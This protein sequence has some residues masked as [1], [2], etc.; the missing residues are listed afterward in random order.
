M[1]IRK[2]VKENPRARENPRT[3]K[4]LIL[5]NYDSFTYNLYQYIGELKGNSVVFRNDELSLAEIQAMQPSHIVISPGPGRPERKKD[6]GVCLEVIRKFEGPILGVCLGHQGMI[7]AM[8][9]KII[10]APEIMHGKVSRVILKG[11][12]PLFRGLSREITVMRYH[13]LI[14]ERRSLPKTLKVIAET[15]IGVK[16]N[17][18]NG[19]KGRGKSTEKNIIMGVQ[20]VS[21]PLFGVQ[22]HPESVGTTVGKQILKNFLKMKF[23]ARKSTA[24]KTRSEK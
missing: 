20:H 3:R 1:K 9:G 18:S 10:Q 11:G 2:T 24:K 15:R 14:G 8:G 22:F 7:H 5:D 23:S 19:F 13:S 6:F 17:G 12:S 21:R 16:S 4:T